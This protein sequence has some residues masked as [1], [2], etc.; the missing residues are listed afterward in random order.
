[1]P[2]GRG[3][4]ETTRPGEVPSARSAWRS[5]TRLARASARGRGIVASNARATAPFPRVFQG[6]LGLRRTRRGGAAGGSPSSRARRSAKTVV[7]P[8][9]RLSVSS[10]P[11]RS[12]KGPAP[13]EANGAGPMNLSGEDA[14]LGGRA[15]AVLGEV[16]VEGLAEG[17]AHV[18]A[19]EDLERLELHVVVHW[20]G[21]L[22]VLGQ[23]GFFAQ[24]KP[25]QGI[26]R[27]RF[28]RGS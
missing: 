11:T 23:L 16:H 14:G 6:T 12:M 28:P 27:V 4:S 2:A 13:P 17:L 25:P 10:T 9:R 7:Q 20:E 1:R 19:L 15:A 8:P 3:A 24:G 21:Q 22:E 5:T 18:L 26:W